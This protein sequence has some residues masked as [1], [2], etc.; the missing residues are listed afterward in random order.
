M[1]RVGIT[2][3]VDDC[4]AYKESRDALDQRWA[5][6]LESIRIC[7]V[8]IPNNLKNVESFLDNMKIDGLLLTGGNNI[9]QGDNVSLNRNRTEK[10]ALEYA[11]R[12]NIPVL[13][14][15]RG[16]Q[17]I[18]LYFGGVL[19]KV[20]GHVACSHRVTMSSDHEGASLM[21]NSYHDYGIHM[22][23]LPDQLT[24]LAWDENDCV[25]MVK[26]STYNITGVMWHPEREST[27]LAH[28]QEIFRK[29]FY[30]KE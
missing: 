30:D 9:E 4:L 1:I 25:E 19:S 7:P 18:V 16:L 27:L 21:V 29:V 22:S 17:F 26:H 12:K 20:S 13:G 23:K 6:L 2:Q 15:C 28:D 14:V 11:I 3:R 24:P 8:I 10:M 5:P